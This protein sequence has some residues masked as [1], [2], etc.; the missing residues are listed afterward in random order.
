MPVE[1]LLAAAAAGFIYIVTPG[2]AF[3][4]LFALVA[5][6]GRG[7]GIRFVGGHLVGDILWGT[8]ALAAIIGVSRLGPALFETLGLICGAYL[9]W[10]GAMAIMTREGSP[11]FVIA[12]ARA[13]A[14]GVLFGLTNP[15]AYPVSLAMFT[16]LTARYAADMSWDQ[17]PALMAAA[18]VG[19][20]LGDAV[21]VGWAGLPAI[22]RFFL[23]HG[24]WVTR[25]VGVT[26]V[27]FGAK[28]IADAAS[29][30]RN[31]T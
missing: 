13:L 29:S 23:R 4:A 12:P 3:L 8:L 11:G 14:T 2:P 5:S 9:I 30:F 16:A 6:E 1:L 19:F 22:R 25:I 27:L 26:F 7:A 24:L 17:A 31:R 20:L 18:L 21:L 10:L 28:S 15:K